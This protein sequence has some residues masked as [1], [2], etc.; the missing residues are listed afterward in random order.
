MSSE[1]DGHYLCINNEAMV[2]VDA[3]ADERATRR[4]NCYMCSI[5]KRGECVQTHSERV[6]ANPSP[7]LNLKR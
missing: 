3:A 5:Q 6:L 2:Q 7:W 1:V 4:K